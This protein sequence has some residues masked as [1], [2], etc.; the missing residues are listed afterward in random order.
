MNV[1]GEIRL[2]N[3]HKV[4][5]SA[6][7]RHVLEAFQANQLTSGEPYL[8]LCS[9]EPELF[10]Y[11]ESVDTRY[12]FQFCLDCD[13]IKVLAAKEEICFTDFLRGRPLVG[14]LLKRY[15]DQQLG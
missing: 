7:A 8:D 1:S 12:E 5:L 11:V 14:T 2:H 3:A 4:M 10:V 13:A 6:D 15:F 9:F